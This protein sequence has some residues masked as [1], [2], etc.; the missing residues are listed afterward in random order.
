M[1]S[2]TVCWVLKGTNLTESIAL[3]GDGKGTNGWL[4]KVRL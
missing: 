1:L 4:L 3:A 2:D